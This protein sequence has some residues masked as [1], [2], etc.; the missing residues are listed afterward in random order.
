M[1]D[2]VSLKTAKV[3]SKDKNKKIMGEIRP[4]P[5]KYGGK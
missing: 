5:L 3:K 4:S 2:I 1:L